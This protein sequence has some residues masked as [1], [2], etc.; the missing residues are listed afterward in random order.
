[1][2]GFFAQPQCPPEILNPPTRRL[3]T[4]TKSR[5][6][7]HQTSA[8]LKVLLYLKG[9]TMSNP[10]RDSRSAASSWC[11]FLEPIAR[12]EPKKSNP[13][14]QGNDDVQEM[15]TLRV[16]DLSKVHLGADG[17]KLKILASMCVLEIDFFDH[18]NFG[19]Q[20]PRAFLTAREHHRVQLFG[21][22]SGLATQGSNFY[23]RDRRARQRVRNFDG[24]QPSRIFGRGPHI[25]APFPIGR[26]QRILVGRTHPIRSRG[27]QI[28]APFRMGQ[29][30]LD[31]HQRP[32]FALHK[33][34]E[35]CFSRTLRA[36]RAEKVE[37]CVA[38]QG[39][40]VK[41]FE[42]SG[43]SQG[44]R[45]SRPPFH[46]GLANPAWALATAALR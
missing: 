23:A 42:P 14:S 27:L 38:R 35:L 41:Q 21:R 25:E 29:P 24:A 9:K 10:S 20:R 3:H 30:S 8:S 45:E 34:I 6:L 28:G 39:R 32:M 43:I 7:R 1:M 44:C 2:L 26:F 36:L 22:T 46:Q 17:E 18:G 5:T 15:R 19:R 16:P 31:T 37:P 4:R 33:I 12:S 13:A 40:C 11:F